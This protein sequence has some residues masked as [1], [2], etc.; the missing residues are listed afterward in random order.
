MAILVARRHVT[1]HAVRHAPSQ[2]HNALRIHRVHTAQHPPV[3]HITMV[4][5]A[6]Q[7]PV[8]VIF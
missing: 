6:V 3:A 8:P 5:R 1:S 7:Q 4:G 2:R